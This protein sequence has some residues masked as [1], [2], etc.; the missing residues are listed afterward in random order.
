MGL[1]MIVLDVYQ[2]HEDEPYMN[3]RQ[4]A[5]FRDRLLE[6]R[7][8]LVQEARR[9]LREIREADMVRVPD[10]LDRSVSETWREQELRVQARFREVLDRNTE[11]LRLLEEGDYGYCCLTGEPI[12]IPRMLAVPDALFSIEAQQFRERSAGQMDLLCG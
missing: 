9:R 7:E 12:G 8:S 11:A 5:W 4:K 2:P 3:A 10:M 6:Q 1:S